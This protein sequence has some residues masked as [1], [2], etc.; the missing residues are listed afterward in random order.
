MIV[1]KT[2]PSA[3]FWLFLSCGAGSLIR[4]ESKSKQASC[5]R[6]RPPLRTR[7]KKGGP[8]TPAA[9]APRS[10]RRSWQTRA[11]R[12]RGGALRPGS[13]ALGPL[14]RIR[15]VGMAPTALDGKIDRC[16]SG[17][18]RPAH[19]GRQRN[20]DEIAIFRPSYRPHIPPKQPMAADREI[21]PFEPPETGSAS[22]D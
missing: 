3:S 5:G 1:S 8:A 17:R 13:V 10:R 11:E 21:D 4:L 22:R 15:E 12:V 7:F 6:G 16:L 9:A 14:D 18:P 20:Q 19:P 2:S